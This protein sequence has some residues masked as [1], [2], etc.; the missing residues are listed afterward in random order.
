MA[1]VIPAV[2]IPA[3][4]GKHYLR[5]DLSKVPSRLFLSVWSTLMLRVANAGGRLGNTDARE[6]A[7]TEIPLE[8]VNLTLEDGFVRIQF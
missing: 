6:F 1:T 3:S 8:L 5:L 4:D 2:A 7:R